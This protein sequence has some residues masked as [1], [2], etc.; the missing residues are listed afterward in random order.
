MPYSTGEGQSY[1]PGLPESL[2]ASLPSLTVGH[3]CG[4][5]VDQVAFYLVASPLVVLALC[6]M[7]HWARSSGR[8]ALPPSTI[9]SLV[10]LM[11]EIV[12]NYPIEGPIMRLAIS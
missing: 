11:E 7:W 8:A 2:F 6:Q 3:G 9:I 1:P 4:S 12:S 10:R 5:W